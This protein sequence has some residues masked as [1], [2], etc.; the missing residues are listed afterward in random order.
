M[1]KASSK[2]TKS[3]WLAILAVVVTVI[4]AAIGIERITTPMQLNSIKSFLDTAFNENIVLYADLDGREL[5]S[6]YRHDNPSICLMD[7][8][9]LSVRIFNSVDD[10]DVYNENVGYELEDVAL[11]PN[12]TIKDA[13]LVDELEHLLM[14]EQIKYVNKQD[15]LVY[16]DYDD[17]TDIIVDMDNK[18]IYSLRGDNRF[19]ICGDL[20]CIGAEQVVQFIE[21]FLN[22][23]TDK[24]V[25]Q[26]VTGILNTI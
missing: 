13:I 7:D 16:I 26:R 9:G 23:V 4:L 17:I 14:S 10:V 22:Q 6:V 3:R 12:E 20:K 5:V 19:I 15:G 18:A 11:Y 1:E 8:G 21:Q 25:V 2:K 24:D